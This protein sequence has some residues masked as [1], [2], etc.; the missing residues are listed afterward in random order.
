MDFHHLL[1]HWLNGKRHG[2]G[3]QV[4]ISGD[5]YVGDWI[6]GMKHGH[7]RC[8]YTSGDNYEGDYKAGKKNGRGIFKQGIL[9]L[10]FSDKLL[11]SP[12]VS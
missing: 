2:F 9:L 8:S 6:D 3:K 10:F 11:H 7:G 4:T 5:I 12:Q 1:G